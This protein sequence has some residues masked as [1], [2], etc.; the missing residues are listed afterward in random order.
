MKRYDMDEEAEGLTL[1][2]LDDLRAA[3]A[4]VETDTQEGG[5]LYAL[6]RFHRWM[7]YFEKTSAGKTDIHLTTEVVDYAYE[8]P[9]LE[10][11]LAAMRCDTCPVDTCP[12]A[13]PG[14]ASGLQAP[15]VAPVPVMRPYRDDGGHE[16]G[17]NAVEF[18]PAERVKEI[19]ERRWAAANTPRETEELKIFALRMDRLY[20]TAREVQ[21]WLDGVDTFKYLAQDEADKDAEFVRKIGGGV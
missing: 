4:A 18:S 17:I 2:P 20:D 8:R 19:F 10:R 1:W 21:T 9:A 6:R 14:I 7:Q 13:A 5:E 11:D 15:T 12:S 16:D 3:F